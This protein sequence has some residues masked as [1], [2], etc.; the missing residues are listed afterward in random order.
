MAKTNGNLALA[1][2]GDIFGA[3]A[4]SDTSNCVA[5]IA[6]AELHAPDCHPFLVQDDEQMS[7]LV[8]SIREHGVREPGLARKRDEG[9]YELLSGN[10]RKRACE[11]IGLKSMPV[12]VKDLDDSSAVIAMVDSN[13]LHRDT[14]LPSEKAWAYKMRM[15]ALNHSGVKA[16][17]HSCDIMAE[18]T[19]EN[20]A[21]IFRLIRLTELVESL[22]NKVDRRE[23][24][25]TPA[26]RLSY[27][28]YDEQHIVA[29]CMAKYEVKPSLSQTVR[30]QKL[31]QAGTLTAEV[32]DSILAEDKK[33]PRAEPTGSMRFRRYFPPDYSAK[34]IETVIIGLLKEWKSAQTATI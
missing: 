31:K 14:L 5:E 11:I 27:L 12:I 20:K 26:V 30:I 22:L 23:L 8:D 3:D 17:K 1:D 18:Q 6:V 25:F 28:S 24:A 16:D 33:P 10:R 7:R 2:F 19:G 34:Q 4:T 9:G 21:T 32:I 15:D 29:D 13:L